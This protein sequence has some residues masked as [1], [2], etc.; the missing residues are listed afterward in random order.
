LLGLPRIGRHDN[1]GAFGRDERARWISSQ[2]LSED[3][4][5]A[6]HLE[7]AKQWAPWAPRMT[8]WTGPGNHLTILP[9]PRVVQLA[10][11]I[12]DLVLTDSLNPSEGRHAHGT[13]TQH[14][15]TPQGK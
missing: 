11:R 15:V 6:R 9:P 7:L 4:S 12:L 14:K 8:P 2:P 1:W 10:H 13:G 3:K 5:L